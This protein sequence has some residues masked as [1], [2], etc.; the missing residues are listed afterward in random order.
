MEAWNYGTKNKLMFQIHLSHPSLGNL[1]KITTTVIDLP[2]FVYILADYFYLVMV[3]CFSLRSKSQESESPGLH[4][5]TEGKE[6][7]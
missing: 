4:V 5:G 6:N 2:Q 1:S 3:D 7:G